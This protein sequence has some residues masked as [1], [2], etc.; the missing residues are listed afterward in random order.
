MGLSGPEVLELESV[1]ALCSMLVQ[2]Q[3]A[4]LALWV[5][6]SSESGIIRCIVAMKKYC[7][8]NVL[9]TAFVDYLLGAGAW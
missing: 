9:V 7:G 5:S 6:D 1:L 3:I 8:P 2:A 4:S